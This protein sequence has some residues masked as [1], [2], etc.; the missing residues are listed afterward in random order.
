MEVEKTGQFGTVKK[1][2]MRGANPDI[3]DFNDRRAIDM[4]R[5]IVNDK[6]RSKAI[7]IL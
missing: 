2:I 5:L 6:V 7:S 1:L 3:K 4:A